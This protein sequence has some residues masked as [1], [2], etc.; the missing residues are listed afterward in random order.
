MEGCCE[1]SFPVI[2]LAYKVVMYCGEGSESMALS[3]DA[4]MT[5][6]SVEGAV[7]LMHV[8]RCSVFV[9]CAVAATIKHSSVKVYIM[10]D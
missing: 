1:F 4:G 8:A 5:I 9:H 7:Q 6:V 2:P 10:C 3:G